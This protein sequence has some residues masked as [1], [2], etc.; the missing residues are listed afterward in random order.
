MNTK[1]TIRAEN[2]EKTYRVYSNP[3]DRLKE[4]L[5]L[6]TKNY[7]RE[8]PGL[9]GIDFEVAKGETVGIV[10]ENGAGK[11]T[12]LKII[13]G[14]SPSTSGKLNIRG[15]VSALL[16]ITA[17]F[18]PDFSGSYNIYMKCTL[19][20]MNRDEIDS[21][22]NDI[23]SFAELEDY[24]DAPLRTYSDGMKMRLGFSIATSVNPD[25]LLIDEVITVG[26]N[27]FQGKCLDRIKELQ[28]AGVTILLV[29]HSMGWV[30]NLCEKAFWIHRGKIKERGSSRSVVDKYLKHIKQ[31]QGKQ[32]PPSTSKHGRTGTGDVSIQK[33]TFEDSE[34]KEKE[35][36]RAG[37]DITVSV[38]YSAE[39]RIENPTV[40][41]SLYTAD[42]S[43]V[44]AFSTLDEDCG[45]RMIEGR[46]V[47]K[48]TFPNISLLDGDYYLTV[49][50]LD[51][52][53]IK[54]YD[55][56][57]KLHSFRIVAKGKREGI[58]KMDYTFE[59]EE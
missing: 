42:G 16:D 1:S 5:T 55:F 20:G 36:F 29:T 24:I 14:L 30:K 53:S 17:G 39:K 15:S 48:L 19:L 11:S 31:Q 2:L 45:P 35:A 38:G 49:A 27:Y 46:G 7:H 22:Y 52:D 32:K 50:I 4:Y 44:T 51:S 9:K 23:V 57:N 59:F 8:H 18:N 6:K 12:L 47:F 3:K 33:V 54:A 13:A 58:C 40:G 21:I 43:K 34:G 26:D 56:H 10:G 25:I 28:D 37:E 41:I